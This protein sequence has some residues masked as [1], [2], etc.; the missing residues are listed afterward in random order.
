MA[1]VTVKAVPATQLVQIVR[2]SGYATCMRTTPAMDPSEHRTF[3]V[4]W[5]IKEQWLESIQPDA[6]GR[7]ARKE[8]RRVTLLHIGT[9]TGLSSASACPSEGLCVRD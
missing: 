1:D 3:S 9:V 8:N 7:G 2:R 5:V 6:F 4:S